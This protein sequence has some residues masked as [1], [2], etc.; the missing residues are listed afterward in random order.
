MY[1]LFIMVSKSN[2]CMWN[3]YAQ[4]HNRTFTNTHSHIFALPINNRK[5]NIRTYYYYNFM[6]FAWKLP[7][8]KVGVC[9]YCVCDSPGISSV[10]RFTHIRT[11]EK[12]KQKKENIILFWMEWIYLD[13]NK[14]N[15]CSCW[16]HCRI[17]SE[18]MFVRAPICWQQNDMRRHGIFVTYRCS[19]IIIGFC[20][21]IHVSN[22]K[23]PLNFIWQ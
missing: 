1:W 14:S 22:T 10:P 15:M 13:T 2:M 9:V 11:Y 16:A 7:N 17:L 21:N 6:L 19:Y 20:S 8:V 18:F 5:K 23:I 3:A 4:S 12:M